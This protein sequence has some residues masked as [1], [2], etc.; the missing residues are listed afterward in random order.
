[1]LYATCVL[2]LN[3]QLLCVGCWSAM[4]SGNFVVHWSALLCCA[5]LC[6]A[7]RWSG[8]V[9]PNRKDFCSWPGVC[10]HAVCTKHPKVIQCGC[11]FESISRFYGI[12]PIWDDLKAILGPRECKRAFQDPFFRGSWFQKGFQLGPTNHPGGRKVTI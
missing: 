2:R 5:V 1:M 8:R 3:E 4:L 9:I 6:P 10:H 7:V 12:G 11:H